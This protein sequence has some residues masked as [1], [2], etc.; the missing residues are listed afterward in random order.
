MQQV[1]SRI[2]HTNFGA[3]LINIWNEGPS[4]IEA[5]CRVGR[6]RDEG[7]GCPGLA[8]IAE[9]CERKVQGVVTD[10]QLR[11]AGRQH[12]SVSRSAGRLKHEVQIVNH[13]HEERVGGKGHDQLAIEVVGVVT[14]V[15][16][17]LEG[18]AVAHL[19]RPDGR[20]LRHNESVVS[21]GH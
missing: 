21:T 7:D 4:S 20:R 1:V 10:L 19:K 12:Y 3:L 17:A 11:V 18:P 5:A 14:G 13:H 9:P 6:A 8:W 15:V 2:S 16:G